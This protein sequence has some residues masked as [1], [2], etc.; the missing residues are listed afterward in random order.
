MGS[1]AVITLR[2][3]A[4][5]LRHRLHGHCVPVLLLR[6]K[7]LGAQLY[8]TSEEKRPHVTRAAQ[9]DPVRREKPAFPRSVFAAGTAKRTAEI[10]RRKA[11]LEPE[12]G[13]SSERDPRASPREE[14]PDA[15]LSPSE[16]KKLKEGSSRPERFEMRMMERM[17][18]DGADVNVA[19]SLL[20]SVAVETGAVPYALLLRYLALCVSSGHHSEVLDTCDV[21]RSCFK[22][23]DTGAYSLLIKGFSRTERWREALV[24]LEEM[25]KVII[26]SV[27]NYGDAIAGAFLHGDCET[28]WRLCRELTDLDLT[29]N[30][31][32]WQ[33]LFQ[34]AT[35]E[36]RDRLLAI[37]H[38][39]RDN[40]IYPE[41]TLVQSIKTWFE[42]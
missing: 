9:T 26:P 33:C 20:G 24:M 2:T 31:D 39:M 38:Y 37:L 6:N 3:C 1:F 28:G 10:L 17:L 23:L 29:P 5:R 27:R 11:G 7:L 36:H 35:P 32:T 21:M 30:Q 40:Q 18:K 22:T 4:Q 42:R 15:P 16:W 14:V 12:Q 34:N 41:E 19:K 8:C 25:K 13:G